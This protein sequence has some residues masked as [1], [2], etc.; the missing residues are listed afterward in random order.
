MNKVPFFVLAIL[1][2]SPLAFAFPELTRHGYTHCSTCHVSPSGGGVMTEYGRSL[3]KEVLSTWSYEGEEKPLHGLFT[4][5]SPEWLAVG[6]DLR[7]I[8]TYLNN[9]Q[10]KQ[11]RYFL[12][13]SDLE[14][15]VRTMK[16][17]WVS[18]F[19]VR[20]EDRGREDEKGDFISRRHYLLYQPNDNIYLRAGQYMAPFGLMIPN[21]NAMIRRSL[22]FFPDSES[23]NIESGWLGEKTEASVTLMGGRPEKD[24]KYVESGFA[25]NTSYFFND[26]NK[27]G[28][29]GWR[30]Q[31]N[32]GRR[33]S[34]GAYGILALAEKFYLLSELDHQWSENFPLAITTESKGW[35][36]YQRLNYVV[37]QGIYP[38][39]VH[40]LS[41]L[42]LASLNSRM[43][44]YGIGLQFYPRP[45][46]EFHLEYQRARTAV[47]DYYD[48][49]FL[50]FHY[51]L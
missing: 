34:I 44:S 32:Q 23:Y 29:S 39:L 21:H 41:Y 42:D 37:S 1:L 15:A 7:T 47:K 2:L 49:A 11:G 8:Q 50:I 38:Y 22:K 40:E 46:F 26:K 4:N 30:G 35:V 31:N 18:S 9:P 48:F 28:L 17:W 20:G 45:H 36:S 19:G 27:I 3:S 10:I 16:V 14:L 6:G 5:S 12:M 51:Y 24:Y 13:Q 25:L 33:T 43:D